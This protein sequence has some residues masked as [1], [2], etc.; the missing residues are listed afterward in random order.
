M[1][2][3]VVIGALLA[4]TATGCS[5]QGSPDAGNLVIRCP[6]SRGAI[7]VNDG[8][9]TIAGAPIRVA[10]DLKGATAVDEGM[11]FTIEVHGASVPARPSLSVQC[12]RVRLTDENVQW[13]TVP[14]RVEE[15]YDGSNA[16]IRATGR[17]GP[18][19]SSDKLV[20][21]TVWLKVA[22]DRHVVTMPGQPIH[23]AR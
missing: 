11:S 15:F 19:W 10:A 16:R 6:D 9:V 17:D 7:P 4:V 3:L 13:D 5:D 23:A 8:Q 22:T 2:V 1:R 21:V 20:D 18:H 14:R 12:V